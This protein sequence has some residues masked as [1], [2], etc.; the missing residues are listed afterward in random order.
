MSCPAHEIAAVKGTLTSE[1]VDRLIEIA[2]AFP[3]KKVLVYDLGSGVGTTA[4]SVFMG[5]KKDIE[6]VSVDNRENEIYWAGIAMQNIG[7]RGDWKGVSGD[8]LDK[9]L[10][11]EKGSID[12]LI[13]DVDGVDLSDILDIWESAMFPDG[14]VWHGGG[15][16]D[17]DRNQQPDKG[18]QDSFPVEQEEEPNAEEQKQTEE[19]EET[20]T[21]EVDS[22]RPPC[23]NC[24]YLPPAEKS[25]V[26]AMR[27]HERIHNQ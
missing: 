11:P 7:R 10:V 8:V 6:I 3:D 21:E 23:K 12:L 16:I 26:H 15:L 20:E 22:E 19:R 13:V 27:A 9:S 18:L 5:R 4:L 17:W 24:G 14:N 2:K 1:E 25:Y